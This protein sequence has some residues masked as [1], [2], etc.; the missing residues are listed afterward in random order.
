MSKS[1]NRNSATEGWQ[2]IFGASEERSPP[3]C[4]ASWQDCDE[5]GAE[6]I[7]Q[8][9]PQSFGSGSKYALAVVECRATNRIRIRVN[10][11][12]KVFSGR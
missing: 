8:T 10:Q 1:L 12:Q 2:E 3:R 11:D 4:G 6:K 5:T 7:H 9:D